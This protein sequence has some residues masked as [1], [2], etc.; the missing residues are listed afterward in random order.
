MTKPSETAMQ[1]ARLNA[2]DQKALVAALNKSINGPYVTECKALPASLH[3]AIEGV[4]AA[5]IDAAAEAIVRERLVGLHKLEGGWRESIAEHE[6]QASAQLIQPRLALEHTHE[7][8]QLRKRADA[9]RDALKGL[10]EK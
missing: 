9:L 5:R 8:A 2:D 1:A 7:A 6:R 4:L 10:E 3:I